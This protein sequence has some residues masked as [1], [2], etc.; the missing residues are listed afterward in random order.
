MKGSNAKQSKALNLRLVLSQIVTLGPLSRADIARNTQLTK[1]TIT[2]IVEALLDIDLIS[3]TGIK[4]VKGAGK[5]SVMLCLNANAAHTL[6]IRIIG[7]ELELG[8]FKLNGECI[9]EYRNTI[10]S[11]T[12]TQY[13]SDSANQ[14]LKDAGIDKSSV[15]GAGL[16]V[17]GA[18]TSPF[19]MH[20]FA[21][22]IQIELA[23]IMSLPVALSDCASACAS[24][25]LLFGEAKQ[26]DSFVYMHIGH[27]IEAAAVYER[28]ALVGHNGLIGALGDLFVTPNAIKHTNHLGRLND[29]AS[30]CALKQILKQPNI[31]A[32]ELIEQQHSNN[33]KVLSWLA[34]AQEPLSLAIHTIESLL[35]PQT[36]IIGG[37]TSDWLLDVLLTKLRPLIPSISQYGDR[38]VIRLIKTPDVANIALKG[39][40]TLPL[41]AALDPNH[42]Q[43]L[44]L[45]GS[46]ELT[47]LQALIYGTIN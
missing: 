23:E 43:T 22:K 18:Q 35:N 24:Y 1:Q 30:L 38:Q 46:T 25:Q 3:Q 16:V 5:P 8:I 6:A 47:E 39:C 11:I 40:A 27:I 31:S 21:Q 34:Q 29:F 15:L 37:D 44:R 26:L 4:K 33:R 36:I 2:N 19:E 42:T 9:K 28:K 41:Q 14:L 12:L 20:N 13:V 10:N 32:A 45:S 17:Q 7:N